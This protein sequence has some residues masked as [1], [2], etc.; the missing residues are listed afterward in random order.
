MAVDPLWETRYRDNPAYRN[1]YPWSSIV[2]FVFRHAPHDRARADI[3]ILE[4]GCGNGAN[5]WFAAR[6][7]FR[8]AGVDGSATA[9]AAAKEWF[10]AERLAGDL[11][12]GDYCA[13]PFG[14]ATFDLV[15]DRA[16]L[17]FASRADAGR[18]VREAWRVLRPGGYLHFN[19]YSKR[20]TSFYRP[21]DP[22]GLVRD[23]RVGTVTGGSAAQFYDEQYLRGMF[24]MG[25]RVHSL[26]H[27]EDAEL[28][29]EGQRVHAE[30]V[31]VAQKQP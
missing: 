3:G 19:P 21:S 26:R 9:I 10:A 23:I 8:V 14:D 4:L 6:E 18:A 30:W 11:R 28:K 24:D 5:L 29:S 17:S 20:S 12:V 27:V 25:W 15:I 22:D 2:T 7:G 1:R 31:L 13:L 16:A